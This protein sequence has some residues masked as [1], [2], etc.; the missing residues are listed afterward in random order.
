[1]CQHKSNGNHE[2]VPAIYDCAC[3][4]EGIAVKI[5]KIRKYNLY[6]DEMET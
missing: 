1:M 3:Q 6:Y 5:G 2:S 4:I